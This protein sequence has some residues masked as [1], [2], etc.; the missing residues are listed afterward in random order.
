MN[1][2]W[3]TQTATTV[4][5]CSLHKTAITMQT[6]TSI[7]CSHLVGCGGR[8]LLDLANVKSA[9]RY[10]NDASNSARPTIPVT[11]SVWIC[12]ENKKDVAMIN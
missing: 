10:Q 3:K 9:K 8:F 4:M 6:I 2:S 5:P 11:A 1:I 12:V 7:N